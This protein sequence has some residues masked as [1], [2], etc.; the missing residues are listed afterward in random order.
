MNGFQ[1]SHADND[2]SST[3]E[4]SDYIVTLLRDATSSHLLETVVSR[5]PD[6]VFGIIWTTYFERGLRKLAMHPV[7]NFVT[8]KALERTNAEQLSYALNELHDSLGK[9]R[10]MFASYML[11]CRC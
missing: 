5:C 7:A 1:T 3:P 11:S 6:S 2:P 10:R 4:A 9:L 8:A